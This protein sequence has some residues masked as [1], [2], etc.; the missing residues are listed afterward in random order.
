M[1]NRPPYPLHTLG[2]P[3]IGPD[4]ELKRGLEGFWQGRLSPE[5]FAEERK[6][7]RRRRWQVQV[8]QGLSLLNVLDFSAYDPM[9]DQAAWLGLLGPAPDWRA[10]FEAARGGQAWEMTKW[11]GTNYH[12]LVPPLGPDT[13]F[14][15]VAGLAGEP[16]AEETAAA[17][18]WGRPLKAVLIGPFTFLKLSRPAP[19]SPEGF[20]PL[21]RLD[22]LLPVY[23]SLL[24]RLGAL[25]V[26][27][28]QCEEPAAVLDLSP[29]EQQALTRSY[30]FLSRSGKDRPRLLVSAAYGALGGNLSA[31]CALPVEG[32]HF[33]LARGEADLPA[34]CAP[35]PA[36]SLQGKTLSLGL[37]DGRNIWAAD[38]GR[39]NRL[40][41]RLEAA[42]GPGAAELWLAP[43]CSLAHVPHSLGPEDKLDPALRRRLAFAEEKLAELGRLARGEPVPS[44]TPVDPTPVDPPPLDPLHSDAPPGSPALAP[45]LAALGPRPFQRSL[46]REQR[47]ALQAQRLNLPPYPTTTIGSFPQTDELRTLRA[48]W[49]RGLVTQE[50][51]EARIGQEIEATLRVQEELG[52]DLL[53]HGEPER[54]DMVEFFGEQLEGFAFTRQAWVQS[55]GSR[56]VKPP[57]LHGPVRRRRPLTVDWARFARSRT[58]KPL[59]GMLTGPIT[60]LQWSFVREDQPRR[61]TAF[62]LALALREEVSE[63]E[64]LGLE[65]IQVDEPGLRE[66]LPLRQA[67]RAAYLDW[68]A[69]AFR[70]AV[71][72][73]GPAT[74]I[75]TH[76]CYAEFK[77]IRPVLDQLEADVISLEASRSRMQL[78]ADLDPAGLG[79]DLGPGIW[80]IH[81]PRVPEE[82]ELRD[83]LGRAGRHLPGDRLWV[84][85][86]CGLK[87][88]RWEE[89]R[90]A[91]ERL[92]AAARSLRPELAEPPES[93]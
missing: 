65:A 45:A 2:Y 87:T 41:A 83:L 22:D 81:S 93:A 89:V 37:I 59:K 38:L 16:W 54:N 75:H 15:P 1:T 12:Y 34:L 43:G 27:W 60:L 48:R 56:C 29:P 3:R 50:Q 92:C 32:L 77:D 31:F 51:Y 72:S 25:G 57:I 23:A 86:D 18:V 46:P 30:E 14:S 35:S 88:R 7:L 61:D 85:P 6:D 68:A 90:P 55:Y 17:R 67:D 84:N 8:D 69:A 40:L 36:L 70:L 47:R 39:Q 53:V 4:R 42:L 52:L 76:M 9:L 82:A 66:G 79:V 11:F 64:A 63:L 74:Q 19:G 44:P 33:D 24:A 78:L 73:A 5:G 26:E 80:D 28:V 91:L 49:R 13:A 21:D 58:A 10:Y 62:E 71:S 20:Q